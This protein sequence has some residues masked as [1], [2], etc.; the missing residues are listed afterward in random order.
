M[1]ADITIN[2]VVNQKASFFAS[3]QL[4]DSTGAV[5]DLSN[6]TACAKYSTSYE[7]VDSAQEFTTAIPAGTDGILTIALDAATT[8]A[9][10]PNVKYVYDIVITDNTT[11]YKTRIVQGTI[12]VSA[13]VTPVNC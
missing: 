9:L 1:A 2:L 3:L 7:A 12:K 4:K 10:D 11:H 8:A 5:Y 13:G 6:S